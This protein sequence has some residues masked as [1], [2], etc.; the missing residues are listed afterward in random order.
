MADEI[1][2]EATA[3]VD[4]QDRGRLEAFLAELP[5]CVDHVVLSVGPPYSAPLDEIDLTRACGALEQLL[6]PLSV[7]RF[8][9]RQM[10]DGGSL[11]V[12]SLGGVQRPVIG[13]AIA[14][15]SSG[16]LSALIANLALEIAPVRVNLI[17][18]AAADRPDDVAALAVHLMTDTATT[19]AT[20]E[21][22]GN[23]S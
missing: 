10:A 6:L 2:V 14:A 11:V 20:Y 3:A 18:A 7:A 13:A 4:S 9:V 12:V 1:G 15:M 23:E 19:G 17:A 8:A 21:I 16:A 22:G 5:T